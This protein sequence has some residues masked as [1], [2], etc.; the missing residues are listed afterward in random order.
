MTAAGR[1]IAAPTDMIDGAVRGNAVPAFRVV[2]K[3]D[4]YELSVDTLC[5][6][7]ALRI[8]SMVRDTFPQENACFQQLAE[9]P[10]DFRFHTG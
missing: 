2:R 7:A 9:F 10:L 8:L 6:T 1:I 5:D 3:A 4:P